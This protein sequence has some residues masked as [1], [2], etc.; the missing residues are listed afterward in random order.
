MLQE[1]LQSPNQ[2]GKS[3]KSICH[4]NTKFYAAN[5]YNKAV[6]HMTESQG[7]PAFFEETSPILYLKV[8]P[9]S[10]KRKDHLPK[11]LGAHFSVR[12]PILCY[13]ETLFLQWLNIYFF[14]MF[15]H[16]LGN[17]F[18]S[19]KKIVYLPVTALHICKDTTYISS[20]HRTWV[21]KLSFTITYICPHR[22]NLLTSV[23]TARQAGEPGLPVSEIPWK[24]ETHFWFGI[25]AANH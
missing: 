7:L 21:P 2:W 1:I 6:S 16:C 22:R 12:W 13:T 19:H 3:P 25:M 5:P 23:P 24:E 14:R 9:Q 18:C 11:G 15:T 8:E 17:V 4:V 20:S 10:S